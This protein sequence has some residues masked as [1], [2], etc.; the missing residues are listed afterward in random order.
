MFDH[1]YVFRK[2]RDHDTKFCI[3]KKN[4]KITVK[5]YALPF[6]KEKKWADD[7]CYTPTYDGTIST[8]RL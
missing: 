4:W 8:I 1:G 2:Y 3:K 7:G 6:F 5:Y